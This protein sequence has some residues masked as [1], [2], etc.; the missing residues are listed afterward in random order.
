MFGIAVPFVSFFSLNVN[1]T[2]AKLLSSPDQLPGFEPY[3][4]LQPFEEFDQ[5]GLEVEPPLVGGGVPVSNPGKSIWDYLRAFNNYIKEKTGTALDVAYSRAVSMFTQ[6]LAYYWGVRLGSGAAGQKPLFEQKFDLAGEMDAAAGEFLNQTLG[7]AWGRDLCQPLDPLAKINIELTARQILEP[8]PRQ[9]ACRA[10][11]ILKQ[12]GD[13][14]NVRLNQLVDFSTTFNP[15][16]NDLGALLTITTGAIDAASVAKEKKLAELLAQKGWKGIID[17]VTGQIRTPASFIEGATKNLAELV[18]RTEITPKSDNP[19]VKALDL[20]IST[21]VNSFTASFLKTYLDKGI[22]PDLARGP[23][24]FGSSGGIA[25]ARLKF[26]SFLK[27]DFF[28]GGDTTQVVADLEACA[29]DAATQGSVNNC[30]IDAGFAQAIRDRKTVRQ[31]LEEGLLRPD[32]AFGSFELG[33]GSYSDLSE[34]P[35]GLYSLRSI[36]ILRKYGIVPIGWELAARYIAEVEK[37]ESKRWTLGDLVSKKYYNDP[38]SP[39]YHLVDDEWVLKA[40]E[41]LVRRSGPGDVISYFQPVPEQVGADVIVRQRPVRVDYNADEQTCIAENNKGECIQFGYCTGYRN[42]WQVNPGRECSERWVSCQSFVA[43]NGAEVAYLQNTVDF[44]SEPF[45]CSAANAGCSWYCASYSYVDGVFTCL[46]EESTTVAEICD[47]DAGCS[48]TVGSET[49]TIPFGGTQCETAGGAVCR[50]EKNS[51]KDFIRLNGSIGEETCPAASE[52]CSR[53]LQ[54]SDL[55]GNPLDETGVNGKITEAKTNYSKDPFADPYASINDVI[56]SEKYLRVAPDYLNCYDTTAAGDLNTAN[57][58]PRCS[59]FAVGCTAKELNCELYTPV[60]DPGDI[61]VPA[62]VDTANDLCPA[63]CAGYDALYEQANFFDNPANFPRVE[64]FIPENQQSCPAVYAGCEE[65]T[66]LENPDEGGESREYYMELRSC[67]KPGSTNLQTYYSW[68]GS[69]EA[70][71]QLRVWSLLESNK[72][73][74]PCTNGRADLNGSATVC[75]DDEN[76]PRT[77]EFLPA[78]KC[79]P[80]TPGDPTDDPE[81]TPDCVQFID[82]NFKTY[83][84]LQPHVVEESDQCVP[85]RRAEDNSVWYAIPQ[86]GRICP[87]PYAGCREYKTTA[88]FGY[89]LVPLGNSAGREDFSDGNSL[90][91]DP[92]FTVSNESPLERGKSGKI[93]GTVSSWVA[94]LGDTCAD[95]AGCQAAYSKDPSLTCTV[96]QG[97]QKCGLASKEIKKGER[98]MVRFWAKASSDVVPVL[99]IGKPD[100]TIIDLNPSK[101]SIIGDGT[102]RKYQFDPVKV[103]N[104]LDPDDVFFITIASSGDVFITNIELRESDDIYVVREKPWNVDSQCVGKEGCAQ[105]EDRRGD[106]WYVYQFSSICREEAVGCSLFVDTQNSED[107]S[108]ELYNRENSESRDDVTVPADAPVYLVDDS[109]KYCGAVDVGCTLVG[110]GEVNR[111]GDALFIPEY[112]KLDPGAYDQTLCLAEEIMCRS[113]T[114]GGEGKGKVYF[115]DPSDRVCE[116]QNA[117]ARYCSSSGVACETGADCSA[118][119]N[120]VLTPGPVWVKKDSRDLCEVEGNPPVQFVTFCSEDT[121]SAD[122]ANC[123]SR[124]CGKELS[125]CTAL[126]DPQDPAFCNPDCP[127]TFTPQGEPELVDGSCNVCATADPNCS[128]GCQTY[129]FL[130]DTLD[131]KSC[132]SAGIDPAEGCVPF[133]DVRGDAPSFVSDCQPGCPYTGEFVDEDCNSVA[134]ATDAEKIDNGGRPGC[135]GLVPQ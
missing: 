86:K 92:A 131:D 120:C 129:Y 80:E 116:F 37:S 20:G 89:R 21:F 29:S 64:S 110:K 58:S 63:E 6:R 52:G 56:V 19:Y 93:S 123:Y 121:A 87:A 109:K 62:I 31:A 49:C 100:N 91:W 81:F 5:S 101:T 1:E 51:A 73:G 118:G 46:D 135:V 2:Y 50:K 83:W 67:A 134:G 10:T 98:Y 42:T 68:Q 90:G 119:E 74:S 57:D 13:L 122:P 82:T 76:D 105:Y 43:E 25:A 95:A 41:V 102:W 66:N 18:I 24:D 77:G 9:L 33:E 39:F 79:G 44:G 3:D 69:D 107:P 28:G 30:V 88:G 124:A 47:T 97:Y 133:F 85:L 114:V 34:I 14:K 127:L 75:Y 104:S 26:A 38:Q 61:P 40:P 8:Q 55:S 128:P 84:R 125:S 17:P 36:M 45:V 103:E 4:P 35:T 96:P 99:G 71:F 22:A 59:E 16:S 48:C 7:N 130:R 126:R 72:D 15:E 60:A 112:R 11:Q 111:D 117:P 78:R 94:D 23:A 27:P 115:K 132:A 32:W 113:Y 65:F 106:D 53:F 108:A 70:G 12:V 54:L